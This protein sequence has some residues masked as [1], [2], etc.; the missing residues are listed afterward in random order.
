MI[1]WKQSF[2]VGVD[3]IDEDHKI[4]IGLVN[5]CLVAAQS[6]NLLDINTIFRDLEK[7]TSFHSFREE[8]MMEA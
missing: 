2:S 5:A 3:L 7:Y 6:G 1:E 8:G 4:L